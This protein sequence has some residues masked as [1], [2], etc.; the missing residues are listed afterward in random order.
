M[1]KIVI[2]ALFLGCLA[3][4]ANADIKRVEDSTLECLSYNSAFNC[5]TG[6]GEIETYYNMYA[7]SL[8]C[9]VALIELSA[10]L[11]VVMMN[12]KKKETV[13]SLKKVLAT[14]P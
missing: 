4:S 12:M 13:N 5:E 7:E 9:K 6:K 10:H 3:S 11:S 2:T 1:R 8:D 14:C